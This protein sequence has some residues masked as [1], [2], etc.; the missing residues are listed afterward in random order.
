MLEIALD[1]SASGVFQKDI[2]ERQKISLKYLDFI[3]ASLKTAGLIVNKRGRKSGYRLS[4][5]PDNIKMLDIYKAFEPGIN[6]VDCISGNFI[7]ELEKEC[8]VRDFWSELNNI[9]I[10]YFESYTLGDLIKKHRQKISEQMQT[11]KITGTVE[12]G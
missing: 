3:I 4:R 11:G 6:V 12:L 1:D 2:A 5:S 10:N 8:A 7:C 9:V